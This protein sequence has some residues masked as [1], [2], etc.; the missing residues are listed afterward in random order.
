MRE[1]FQSR[2]I[3]IGTSIR[4]S[5]AARIVLSALMMCLLAACAHMRPKP[6]VSGCI[7]PAWKL[8]PS[9]Y[10]P[11]LTT[12]AL[13]L[14]TF[15]ESGAAPQS[16]AESVVR[17]LSLRDKTNPSP[18]RQVLVLSGGS[19]HGAFGAGFFRGLQTGTGIP[20]NFIL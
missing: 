8:L 13:E 11:K 4:T 6:P 12:S 5:Q 18:R 9:K 20:N 3:I 17:Q 2:P 7:L 10:D 19:Q 15:A 14:K 1:H 16:F